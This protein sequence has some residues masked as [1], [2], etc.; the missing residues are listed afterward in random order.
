M[1]NKRLWID[2]TK[3]RS[4]LDFGSVLN[5]YQL[6]HPAGKTQLKVRCPF[7]EE[8]TP[9][10]SIHVT[11]GKFH[12][13]GCGAKGNT[14]EFVARMEG[15]DPSV[16]EELYESALLALA[17]VGRDPAEFSR[18]APG[19]AQKSPLRA[20]T[21][22]SRPK[23]RPAPQTR[24]S[25]DSGAP[26]AMPGRKANP[27]LELTLTVDPVHPFLAARGITPELAQTF[28]MGYCAKGLM[29]HRIAIP[30]HNAA[31]ELVAYAG[32]YAN[33]EVPDG[34]ERYRLPK[35]FHKSLELWNLHRAKTLGKRHLV[36]VE[37]F[38]SAIRLH[39]A[40]IPV[41]ALLGTSCSPEQAEAIR[42]AGFRFVTLLLDGDDA[43]RK[44]TPEI[45]ATLARQ[46]YVRAVELPDG[47]KPDVM[48][49]VWFERLV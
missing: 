23:P 7:H 36:L 38:W 28:G 12:C 14:L 8:H 20:S 4:A 21:V 3:V 43:G 2:Y 19:N 40:G 26:G 46:V 49:E 22:E 39:Q 32:R 42:E 37:G 6:E 41:C 9:S 25:G 24:H 34:V 29:N 18:G 15:K 11:D 35:N 48:P 47:L 31:G 16:K 17:I 27:I 44:A 45:L 30:I 1:K 13:F 10:M 5:H 33:D